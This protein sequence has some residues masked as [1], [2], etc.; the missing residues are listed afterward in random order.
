MHR[1]RVGNRGTDTSDATAEYHRPRGLHEYRM[2]ARLNQ[3]V[4]VDASTDERT[5]SSTCST[6]SS[7]IDARTGLVPCS[8]W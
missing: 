8:A 4:D 5:S 3:L 1:R 7:G 6:A 2:I